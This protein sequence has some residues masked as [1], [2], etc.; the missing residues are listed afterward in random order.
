MQRICKVLVY[1]AGTAISCTRL[2]AQNH[3]NGSI[4]AAQACFEGRLLMKNSMRFRTL[5][6]GIAV[7]ALLAGGVGTLPAKAQSG[8]VITIGV[9]MPITGKEGKPGQYQKDGIE[10]AIKQINDSG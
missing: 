7:V 6:C 1:P 9:V 3:R 2:Y 4:P 5:L 8:D 10:L